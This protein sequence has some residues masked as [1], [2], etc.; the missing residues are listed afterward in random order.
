MSTCFP[1]W[2]GCFLSGIRHCRR[3]LNGGKAPAMNY[4][5]CNGSMM[6]EPMVVVSV[7]VRM[8]NPLEELSTVISLRTGGEAI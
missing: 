5:R 4:R 7:S 8:K 3:P 2:L 6:Q 1:P